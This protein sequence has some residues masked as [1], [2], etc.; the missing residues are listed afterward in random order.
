VLVYLFWHTLRGADTDRYERALVT[1]HD[2]L[3]AA[4]PTGF[5]RSWTVQ[6][7]APPWLPDGP[8]H[9]LDWYMVDDFAG[10]G[11]LNEAAVTGTRQGPHEAAAALARAGTAGVA[12][13]IAGAADAPGGS[14][15]RLLMVDKPAGE[16]YDGFRPTLAAASA[17]APCWMRQMTLGPGPEFIVVAHDAR[18]PALPWPALELRAQMVSA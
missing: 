15:H 6:V 16:R 3:A 12:A 14:G 13:L 18:P 8:A 7:D 5:V 9:Y 1:F 10:L 2:A 11:T 17:G 4:P